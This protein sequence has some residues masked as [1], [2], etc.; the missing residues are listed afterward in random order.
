MTAVLKRNTV[1]TD[2]RRYAAGRQMGGSIQI[3]VLQLSNSKGDPCA[4]LGLLLN[5]GTLGLESQRSLKLEER[6]VRLYDEL[7]EP[8]YRYLLC[9]GLVSEE[10]EEVIQEAF[11]RLYKH[12]HA[13]GREDNLRS[14]LYRVAHNLSVNR[15]KSRQYLADI[16]PERWQELALSTCDPAP[17]PEEVLLEKERMT[18]LHSGIAALS[19]L[20]RNCVYLRVEGFRYREIA[21]ILGVGIPTV[22]ESLRR[23]IVTLTRGQNE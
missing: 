23:A 9:L 18:R 6:I 5:T 4:S 11:L 10:V 2:S 17:G 12:L 14:W 19:E 13:G 3:S 16:S 8:L 7:R 21:A 15:T 20:Q 22:S 1:H